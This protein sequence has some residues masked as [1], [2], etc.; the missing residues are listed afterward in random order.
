MR[1]YLRDAPCT[2]CT[3][4]LRN[5]ELSSNCNYNIQQCSIVFLE[6]LVVISQSIIVQLVG[7]C[8]E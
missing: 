1:G 6:T 3:C 2:I 5:F 7:A 8:Y 4:D